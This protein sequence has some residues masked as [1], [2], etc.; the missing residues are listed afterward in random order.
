MSAKEG[1][2]KASTTTYG[3]CARSGTKTNHSILPLDT[4][5]T[6]A[7]PTVRSPRTLHA[8]VSNVSRR[9]R[10]GHARA[11]RLRPPYP[12]CAFAQSSRNAFS[13][14]SVNGCFIICWITLNGTVHT[15]AP[16]KAQ[17]T[18]C[19]GL[20]IDAARIFVW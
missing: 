2:P 17:L 13:P 1:R 11:D 12:P 18:R 19:M 8:A 3:H 4:F 10:T 6:A 9:I 7:H 14:V 15:S 20:R 5:G 16:I